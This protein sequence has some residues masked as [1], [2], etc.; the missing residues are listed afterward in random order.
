MQKRLHLFL[1]TLV[2]VLVS[3]G[4]ALAMPSDHQVVPTKT[5]AERIAEVTQKIKQQPDNAN[6]YSMRSYYYRDA[7]ELNKAVADISK[8]HCLTAGPGVLLRDP[9]RVL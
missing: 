9:G 4:A 2:L 1:L 6:L 3:A 5:P 8:G 7:H